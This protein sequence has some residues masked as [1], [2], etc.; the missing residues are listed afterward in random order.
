MCVNLY[1][2][3]AI[4]HHCG[5]HK[6]G[7]TLGRMIIKSTHRVLGHSLL[8]AYSFAPHT[9]AFFTLVGAR[10][11]CGGVCT[12]VSISV[13]IA[14]PL[15]CFGRTMGRMTMKLTHRVLGHSLLR[16]CSL[17]RSHRTLIHSHSLSFARALRCAYLFA[18]SPTHSHLSSWERG[19]CP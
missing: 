7:R 2:C 8:H 19:F 15:N 6:V 10:I 9:F 11:V 14:A 12:C 5:F 18:R 16:S 13:V 3:F 1:V 4:C 17:A